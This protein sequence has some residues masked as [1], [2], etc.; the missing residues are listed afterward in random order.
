L[1]LRGLRG[2]TGASIDTM[3]GMCSSLQDI[4]SRN[5]RPR[6]QMTRPVSRPNPGG[7]PAGVECGP[8]QVITG[9]RSNSG[10]YMDHL[11]I[12]CSDV[13]PLR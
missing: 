13:R 1:V 11:W 12:V 4:A 3:V 6:T 9:F 8:G 5:P 7:R 2:N 10:E